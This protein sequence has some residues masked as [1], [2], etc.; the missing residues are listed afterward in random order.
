MR[1]HTYKQRLRSF[2]L[3]L[4]FND[5]ECQK[6]IFDVWQGEPLLYLR[7]EKADSF[8]GVIWKDVDSLRLLGTCNIKIDAVFGQPAANQDLGFPR[9]SLI[10]DL[11]IYFNLYVCKL[12]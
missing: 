6:H 4:L 2:G 12:Y 5:V 8:S 7:Q 1:L 10:L 3:P 11:F 9:K